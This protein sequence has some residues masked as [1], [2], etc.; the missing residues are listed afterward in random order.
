MLMSALHSADAQCL[1]GLSP[2]EASYTVERNGKRIGHSTVSLAPLSDGQWEYRIQTQGNKGMAALLKIRSTETVTIEVDPAG[3]VRPL[4]YRSDVSSRVKDRQRDADFDWTTRRATGNNDGDR[5]SLPLQAGYTVSPMLNLDIQLALRKGQDA[6]E[7]TTI[8]KGKPRSM[9]FT[10]DQQQH[11]ETGL[12]SLRATEVN[13]VRDDDSSRAT[14]TW[15]A[16]DLG[17]LP[18]RLEQHQLEKGDDTI[19]TLESFTQGRICPEG[20]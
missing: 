5:W 2:F 10:R 7:G 1:A 16:Q 4:R 11:I 8:D 20:S 14:V 9:R 19:M 15:F 18:I 17:Y 13:R 12:G 6:F 3:S